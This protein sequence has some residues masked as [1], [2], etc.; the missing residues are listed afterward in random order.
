M[1]TFYNE[2]TEFKRVFGATRKRD[3]TFSRERQLKEAARK[4]LK[5]K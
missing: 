2:M 5:R 4:L 3:G 1:K